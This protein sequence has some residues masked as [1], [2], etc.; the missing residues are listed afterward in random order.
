MQYITFK[1]PMHV[2]YF[3]H[4]NLSKS[5]CYD[6]DVE[7]ELNDDYFLNNYSSISQ[8][9]MPPTTGRISII[10]LQKHVYAAI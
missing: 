4:L 6:F 5:G 3:N 2:S 1:K 10:P 9:L 8:S 7:S